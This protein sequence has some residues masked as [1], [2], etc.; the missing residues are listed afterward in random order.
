MSLVDVMCGGVLRVGREREVVGELPVSVVSPHLS[1]AVLAR[2]H[3]RRVQITPGYQGTQVGV[4]RE[5]LQGA[6]VSHGTDKRSGEAARYYFALKDKG[7]YC[8][9]AQQ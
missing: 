9:D 2:P 4:V 3:Q 7:L 6:T 5:H 8:I 1:I